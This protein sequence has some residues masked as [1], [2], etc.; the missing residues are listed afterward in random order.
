MLSQMWKKL[1]EYLRGNEGNLASFLT[2]PVTQH[3]NSVV[4]RADLPG[5]CELAGMAQM[6]ERSIILMQFKDKNPALDDIVLLREYKCNVETKAKTL[7]QPIYLLYSVGPIIGDV[8]EGH[9]M[10]LYEL[11]A[12]ASATGTT[13]STTTG[14]KP[15]EK[16]QEQAPH[17]QTSSK[18]TDASIDQKQPQVRHFSLSAQ[19]WLLHIS[20]SAIAFFSSLIKM[21]EHGDCA[22]Q[23]YPLQ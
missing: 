13:A 23:G 18:G 19:I 6:L 14:T 15:P 1:H 16:A 12:Q 2:G 4:S 5:E 21:S 17:T 9:F 8:E 10:T 3:I 22:Y 11:P 7:Q 20:C